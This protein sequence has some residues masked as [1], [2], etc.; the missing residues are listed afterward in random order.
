MRVNHSMDRL[1]KVKVQLKPTSGSGWTSN[2]SACVPLF[3]PKPSWLWPPHVLLSP[4]FEIRENNG[5][6]AEKMRVNQAW[7]GWSGQGPTKANFRFWV[8]LE[9]LCM[10]SIIFPQTF[11]VV[12]I[13]WPSLCYIA[14]RENNGT[15]AEQ[16]WCPHWISACVPLFLPK[17]SWL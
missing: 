12:T 5:T 17:P 14:I 4:T 1:V 3:F 9:Y 2:I 7:I 8:D 13:S 15:H 11:V 6:H 10:C 16:M